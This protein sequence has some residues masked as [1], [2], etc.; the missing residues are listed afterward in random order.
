MQSLHRVRDRLV[1]QRTALINQ[2]RAILL[3]RGLVAPQGRRKL[4][5]RL[6][7]WLGEEGLAARSAHALACRGHAGGMAD[8][9]PPDRSLR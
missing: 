8:A 5:R 9:G 6:V 3:E 7:E 2:L 1:G 4:E